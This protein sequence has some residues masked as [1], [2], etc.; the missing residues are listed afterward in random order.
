MRIGVNLL[1][2]VLV[3]AVCCGW[4]S[5]ASLYGQET[6]KAEALAEGPPTSELSP[7]IAA[8]L[9]DTGWKVLDNGG[10]TLYEIWLAKQWQPEA[11]FSATP[12]RQFGLQ[13][14]SFVGVMRLPR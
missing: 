13:P 9:Q 5:V 10:R 2:A 4:W 8:Q 1:R 12:Q 14:G 7:E 11:D 6:F 3:V